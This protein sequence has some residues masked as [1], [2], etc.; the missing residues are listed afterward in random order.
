VQLRSGIQTKLSRPGTHLTVWGKRILKYSFV[1]KGHISLFMWIFKKK[2]IIET[3]SRYG[4]RVTL[5]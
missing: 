1:C 3:I 4:H 2:A 5:A